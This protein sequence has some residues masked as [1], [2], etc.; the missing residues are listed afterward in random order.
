M[1]VN[2][3]PD[4]AQPEWPAVASATGAV[5]AAEGDGGDDADGGAQTFPETGTGRALRVEDPWE[6][7]GRDGSDPRELTVRIDRVEGSPD[8]TDTSRH[9]PDGREC[10]AS[11]GPVFV[12]ASGRRSRRF[13]RFGMAVGIACGVYA[14][15]IV[16]TLLSG[17]SNAPWLPVPGQADDR[18][19]GEVDTSPAPS[20][21][22]RPP[23]TGGGVVV[24]GVPVVP[25]VSGLPNVPG[26]SASASGS[27]TP[28]AGAGATAPRS[29]AGPW[30]GASASPGPSGTASGRPKPPGTGGTTGPVVDPT[31]PPA[32]TSPD[33]TPSGSGGASS[34]DPS[35]SSGGGGNGGTGGSDPASGTVAEGPGSPVPVT[36]GPAPGTGGAPGPTTAPGPT[37]APGP[38]GTSAAPDASGGA[39]APASSGNLA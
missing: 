14:V 39:S 24:P 19:A 10:G 38:A 13:R 25:G 36:S 21:P 7:P 16:V 11:E 23:G 35:P 32:S 3:G 31:P 20:D 27:G 29:S 37:S 33:P 18:P 26:I 15:V 22:A 28:S 4:E 30:P 5:P 8:D 34:P 17:N 1:R 2:K 9:E 12:D 6:E